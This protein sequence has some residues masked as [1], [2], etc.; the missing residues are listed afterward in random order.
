M[1]D[2]DDGRLNNPVIPTE[3]SDEGARASGG[4]PRMHMAPCC[5][6]EFARGTDFSTAPLRTFD[7]NLE[8]G[9]EESNQPNQFAFSRPFPAKGF[10]SASICANLRLPMTASGP[11]RFQATANWLHWETA[12]TRWRFGSYGEASSVASLRRN[13]AVGSKL[14]TRVGTVPFF[15]LGKADVGLASDR[16]SSEPLPLASPSK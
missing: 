13:H 8:N 10:L 1:R 14:Q 6:R 16:R 4:I 15:C 5:F 2:R 9:S 7:E 11:S 3:A 12:G